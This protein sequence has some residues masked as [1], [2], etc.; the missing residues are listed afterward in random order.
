MKVQTQRQIK[1]NARFSLQPQKAKT[2]GAVLKSAVKYLTYF[3]GITIMLSDIFNG[4]SVALA[5]VGGVAVGFGTQSLVKDII[6]GKDINGV[7]KL[8]LEDLASVIVRGG[9]PAAIDVKT[10]AKYRISKEYV[11]LYFTRIAEFHIRV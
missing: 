7:S 8:S 4:V 1:S 9:W 11:K 5:G 3:V 10:D 6:N 2:I